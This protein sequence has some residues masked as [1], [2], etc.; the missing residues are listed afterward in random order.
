MLTKRRESILRIIIGEYIATVA[1]VGSEAIVLKYGLGSSPATVRNEMAALEGEGFIKRPHPSAGA[2]PSDKGYRY[3]VESILNTAKLSPAEQQTIRHQFHQIE[4]S[5]EEWTHLAAS[6]MTE[7]V[8]NVALATFPK[9]PHARLKRLELVLL[10]E[11]LA[12]LILILQQAQVKRQI[13]PLKEA[14]TQDALT[15]AANSL[16]DRFEGLTLPDIQSKE[17]GLTLL[18]QQVMDVTK[19]VM[20]EQEKRAFEEPYVDGLRYLLL[21]PEFASKDVAHGLMELLEGDDFFSGIIP[22]ILASGGLRVIIGEEN[23]DEVLRH[24][25]L[26]LG[27]YGVPGVISGVIGILGPT[28]LAY[29][30][31]IANVDYISTLLGQMAMEFQRTTPEESLN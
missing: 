5:L 29:G 11:Y 30:R 13:I 26:V 23:Q 12:L 2:V 18:E 6:I 15:F 24:C 20:Q 31:A 9:S 7:G 3:Y 16:N 10:H 21:Q 17:A 1:P 19:R 27:S 8:R 28:R 22:S 4:G 25:S 14:H